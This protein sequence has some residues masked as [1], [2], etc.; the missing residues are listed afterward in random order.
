MVTDPQT[1]TDTN[2]M[3]PPSNR[4]DR[5][6][7]LRC[8]YSARCKNYRPDNYVWVAVSI[9][10]TQT[11]RSSYVIRHLDHL[12][13]CPPPPQL[14]PCRDRQAMTQLSAISVYSGLPHQLYRSTELPRTPNDSVYWRY[15]DHLLC[16][17]LSSTTET[18]RK[19]A[20]LL[21]QSFTGSHWSDCS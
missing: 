12:R 17:R 15:E 2:T 14:Q 7:Y 1:H 20:I 5:L 9:M 16:H 18:I 11:A 8:S 3:H 13:G 10:P 21:P 19:I 6:Q 4:Q